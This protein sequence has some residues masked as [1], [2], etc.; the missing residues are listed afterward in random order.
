MKLHIGS[1]STTST[2]PLLRDPVTP[3]GHAA[4]Q[5]KPF[6]SQASSEAL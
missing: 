3:F 6:A 2:E 1:L 4:D 5:P